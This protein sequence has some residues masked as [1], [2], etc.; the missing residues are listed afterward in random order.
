MQ[1][2]KGRQAVPCGAVGWG[3]NVVVDHRQENA[4][5]GNGQVGA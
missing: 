2:A 3:N 4:H 1:A 5:R